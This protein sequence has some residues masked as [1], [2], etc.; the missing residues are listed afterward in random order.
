MSTSTPVSTDLQRFMD[1]LHDKLKGHATRS[2][3]EPFLELWS[4]SADASIMAAVGGY[5]V[6]FDEVSKLL[7]WVSQRLRSDTYSA[8]TLL[9]HDGVDLAA[10][11]ELEKYTSSGDGQEMTLRVTHVYRKEDGGWKLLH[12]HAEQLTPVDETLPMHAT[13]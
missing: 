4:H 11:V 6:G 7:R 8:Q 2:D 9:T 5:H 10:S 3:T 13:N 12:R 1:D